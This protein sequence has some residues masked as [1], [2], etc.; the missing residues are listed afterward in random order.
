MLT[1]AACKNAKPKDQPFKL[2]D[3]KGLYLLIHPNGSKYWR[4]KYRVVGTEKLLALGVYPE[5]TLALARMNRD[6]ART[7]HSMGIDPRETPINR[8]I[9]CGVKHCR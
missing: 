5:V 8:V 4:L 9:W 3:E 7:L 1:A 6:E 2:Y